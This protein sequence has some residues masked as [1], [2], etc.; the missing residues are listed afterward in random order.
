MIYIIFFVSFPRFYH[1]CFKYVV[2]LT[3]LEIIRED[4]NDALPKKKKNRS[5]QR[6]WL[7]TASAICIL[8][9]YPLRTEDKVLLVDVLDLFFLFFFLFHIIHLSDARGYVCLH[10][11]V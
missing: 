4:P 3:I 6:V 8:P 2:D 1:D 9:E 7:L 10:L 5:F 11:C